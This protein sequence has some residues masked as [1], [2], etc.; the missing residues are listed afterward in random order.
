MDQ[1]NVTGMSC[2]ACAARVEKAVCSVAGVE[3]CTVNLLTNSMI[4][5]GKATE[6]E[7]INAVVAAGYGATLKGKSQPKTNETTVKDTETPLVLKR[8]VA[9]IFFLLI[10]MYISMG[11]MMWGFPLPKALAESHIAQGILQ[12]L[13]SATVMVINQK[14]FING[15]K[16]L[17]K[18]SPNMDTLIAI[19]SASAFGYSTYALFKM[20]L[21]VV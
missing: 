2:A 5:E 1:Y 13:L 9:S 17:V 12:L 6:T 4:V 10:L 8:L 14:F 16:G 18:K 20:A 7:I 19:G 3:S 21:E 15:F 11:H